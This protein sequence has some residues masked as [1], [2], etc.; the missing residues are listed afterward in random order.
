M[1]SCTPGLRPALYGGA[2][3]AA[4]A[5]PEQTEPEV[6]QT[7]AELTPAELAASSAQWSILQKA[8]LFGVIIAA[9]L[10]YLRV[11]GRRAVRDAAVRE[12]SLA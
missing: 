3:W 1:L 2:Q 6:V 5:T 12:K 8:F 10:A 4:G 7:P 9:V 11:S